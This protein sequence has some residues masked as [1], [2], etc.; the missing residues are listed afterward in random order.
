ML[1]WGCN[2]TPLDRT[3]GLGSLESGEGEGN[4]GREREPDAK[5]WTVSSDRVAMA[6]GKWMN[7]WH[8]SGI[9]VRECE[10]DL[11]AAHGVVSV[12]G[13]FPAY[14]L[15]CPAS[16]GVSG[17]RALSG[18]AL[19]CLFPFLRRDGWLWTWWWMCVRAC[20]CACGSDHS[21][22]AWATWESNQREHLHQSGYQHKVRCGREL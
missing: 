4:R 20:V 5:E 11:V 21:L 8:Q 10:I 19:I 18:K 15:V 9:E 7:E 16:A 3:S 2:C 12:I 13:L 17:A 1:G 22:Q 14:A 6:T